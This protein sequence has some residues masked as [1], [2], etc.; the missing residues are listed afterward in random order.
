M[1]YPHKRMD[2]EVRREMQRDKK[3]MP[4]QIEF[5]DLYRERRRQDKD[6]IQIESRRTREIADRS[7][8][9]ENKLKY[10]GTDEESA[11][12]NILLDAYQQHL[13]TVKISLLE[14]VAIE[15]RYRP[16]RQYLADHKR[17]W[18]DKMVKM[19]LSIC[20]ERKQQILIIDRCTR[21]LKRSKK[22][23]VR[24]EKV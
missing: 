23:S 21:R 13:V 18:R 15:R 8:S 10:I 4:H 19:Q 1:V 20:W 11:P 16:V 9:F 22:I 3:R 17:S 5:E 14:Q 12:I 24:N 6:L 7:Q 2:K